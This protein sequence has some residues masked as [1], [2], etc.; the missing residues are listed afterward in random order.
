MKIPIFEHKAIQPLAKLGLKSSF[1]SI[2]IETL[3]FTWIS[4]ALIFAVVIGA[5]FYFKRKETNPFSFLIEQVT[6]FFVNLCR[7]SFGFFDYNYFAFIMALFVFTLFCNISGAL[8]FVGEPTAD[9]NTALA[10]G[11]AS[12]FYVQYQKIR[13][14]GILGYLKEYFHPI[15]ILFPLNVIGEFAKIASMSFR[16]FGNVLGGGIIII[17]AIQTVAP[18]RNF[19]MMSVAL[20]LP[21]IWLALKYINFKKPALFLPALPATLLIVLSLSRTASPW[22]I[23][24]TAIIGTLL[25]FLLTV[26]SVL[27]ATLQN[28]KHLLYLFAWLLV[29]FNL[30]EG[31][32]QAFVI[33]MLTVT[34]LSLVGGR[35]E[36]GAEEIAGDK[37]TAKGAPC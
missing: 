14:H 11:I 28:T 5:H 31:M 36:E 4:M 1:W 21:L 17:I 22:T 23:I 2:H 25:G 16:L 32:I 37:S 20:G 13:I 34:Y 35:E 24:L 8:P 12:F 15:F 19:F 26:R 27:K 29:F 7:D 9:V 3:I 10:C 30:F 6:E 33:T 18:Y